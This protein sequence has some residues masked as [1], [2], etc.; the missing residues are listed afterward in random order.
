MKRDDRDFESELSFYIELL[1]NI[2]NKHRREI[3]RLCY[4]KSR[5]ISELVKILKSSQ[6]VTWNNVYQME[7]LGLVELNKRK[8]ER[9]SPVFVSTTVL[10]EEIIKL[11]ELGFE[12]LTKKIKK[13]PKNYIFKGIKTRK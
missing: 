3:L 13:E 4:E 6:K 11:F 2:N 5:T 7:A 8:R 1:Q 9:G 12:D 10:P